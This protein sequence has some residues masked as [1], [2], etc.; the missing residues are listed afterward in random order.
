MPATVKTSSSMGGPSQRTCKPRSHRASLSDSAVADYV[1]G[2]WGEGWGFNSVPVVQASTVVSP[3][4]SLRPAGQS[5][6]AV[7]LGRP[8]RELGPF[9][10]SVPETESHS[11]P[12]P[13]PPLSLTYSSSY[14]LPT[15]HRRVSVVFDLPTSADLLPATCLDSAFQLS[16][17]PSISSPLIQGG[18]F[19]VLSDPATNRNQTTH[20]ESLFRT[21]PFQSRTLGAKEH[22][23]VFVFS[24]YSR[25]S[26]PSIF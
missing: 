5:N 8:T 24:L 14:G 21:A 17:S 9:N 2:P 6:D 22:T 25:F 18:P 10:P 19:S 13:P 20:A 15:H 16:P 7:A 3:P 26:L 23:L 12:P 4:V 1:G 11:S